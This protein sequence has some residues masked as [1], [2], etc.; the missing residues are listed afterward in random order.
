MQLYVSNNAGEYEPA[1]ESVLLESARKIAEDKLNNRGPEILGIEAAKK[2]LPALIGHLEHETLCAIFLD[3]S[4]HVVGFEQISRGTLGECPAHPREVAKAALRHHNAASV[5]LA[6]NHP[7]VA[8]TTPSENDKRVTEHM[9]QALEL[10]EIRLLDHMVVS[11]NTV[12]SI[13]EVMEAE[14]EANKTKRLEHMPPAVKQAL[15]DSIKE[16]V[17]KLEEEKKPKSK[18]N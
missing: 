6:H 14:A 1:S 3:L 18:L 5:L 13:A 15:L 16:F 8:D 10:I 11:G 17:G 2:L 12:T 7:N 9:A 4:F